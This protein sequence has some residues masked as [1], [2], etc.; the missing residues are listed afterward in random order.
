MED[1]LL[2]R[3]GEAAQQNWFEEL[4]RKSWE[5]REQN[6]ARKGNKMMVENVGK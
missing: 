1:L 6:D 2:R 5:K 3:E 4:G